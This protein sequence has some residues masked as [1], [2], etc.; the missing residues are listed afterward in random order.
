M[1]GGNP[2]QRQIVTAGN[3]SASGLNGTNNPNQIS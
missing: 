1:Q 2:N 3:Q